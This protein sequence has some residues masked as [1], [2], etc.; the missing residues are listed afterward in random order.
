VPRYRQPLLTGCHRLQFVT[1]RSSNSKSIFKL[2]RS[3][4]SSGRRIHLR[5]STQLFLRSPRIDSPCPGTS[6][7]D[8]HTTSKLLWISSHPRCLV[9]RST[10][11]RSGHS[12]RQ[13]CPT[14]YTKLPRSSS[15]IV[16]TF[17][18]FVQSRSISSQRLNSC[19]RRKE[20][21]GITAETRFVFPRT[22]GF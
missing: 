13:I 22:G 12:P 16:N 2:A 11:L 7:C 19:A 15:G 5:C 14:C 18:G 6:L 10:V 3:R 1:T 9:T 8:A 20:S 17:T 21:R 4:G